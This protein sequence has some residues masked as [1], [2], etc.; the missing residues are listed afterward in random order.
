VDRAD[1]GSTAGTS[2]RRS[3]CGG[4]SSGTKHI[5]TDLTSTSVTSL[6]TS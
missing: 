3:S 2:R 4:D 6:M 5:V 1:A